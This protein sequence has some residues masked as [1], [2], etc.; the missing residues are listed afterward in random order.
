MDFRISGNIFKESSVRGSLSGLLYTAKQ[1][2]KRID[3][4]Y[5]RKV[6]WHK[7]VTAFPEGR[8]GDPK[9]LIERQFW[10]LM[11]QS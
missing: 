3:I 1:L 11:T 6:L 5:N 4:V 2:E 8:R 9:W 10:L 7:N